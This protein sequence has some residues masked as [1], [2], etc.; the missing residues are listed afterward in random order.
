VQL[1]CFSS[2]KI[3]DLYIFRRNLL[4]YLTTVSENRNRR[5]NK[6]IGWKTHRTSSILKKGKR[7]S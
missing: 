6:V 1:I 7:V 2:Y 4:L 3:S 5:G